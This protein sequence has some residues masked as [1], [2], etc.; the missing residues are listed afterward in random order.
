MRLA[1]VLGALTLAADVSNGMAV[2]KGLRTVLVALRLS[3]R[4]V[5]EREAANVYWVGVLR[6]VGCVG[7]APE[8]AGFA[9]GDDNA[10]RRSMAFADFSRPLDMLRHAAES[11]APEIP[12]LARA[13]GFA[14]FM[15]PS[16]PRRYAQ[17]HCETA[18]F[19]ARSLGMSEEIAKA[20]DT[21][22]EHFD[23]RGP[24][25]LAGDELPWAA[26]VSE[27]AYALELFNWTG[28][29][30]LARQVLQARRGRTLDP[31]LIDA[32][33]S[34]LPSLVQGFEGSVWDEYLASERVEPRTSEAV[35]GPG[36]PVS[37]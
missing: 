15:H 12:V 21:A 1:E 35:P 9:A 31:T 22:G 4:L 13:K 29:L 3:R 10:L 5:A 18:V 28:G 14:K 37:A 7:F 17:A 34:D 36:Y 30:E 6:L 25:G 33:L 2:E 24:R 20:L 32:A 19:F 8:Q 27:V 16:V 11:Y 23:G 26:R